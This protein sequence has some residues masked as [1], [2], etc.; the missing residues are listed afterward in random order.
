M[1]AA[2]LIDGEA[3]RS[4]DKKVGVRQGCPV[5]PPLFNVFINGLAVKLQEAGFGVHLE[6]DELCALLYAD[7]VVLLAGSPH[8]LQQLIDIVAT[9]C[10]TWRL[11]VNMDKSKVLVVKGGYAGPP[12]HQWK[13]RGEILGQVAEYKY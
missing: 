2:V 10:G 4:V 11:T 13:Y 7:D 1:Q 8:D 9:Y 12:A 5:S 6:F 3:S